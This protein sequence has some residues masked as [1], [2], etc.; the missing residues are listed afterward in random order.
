MFLKP[1][2]FKSSFLKEKELTTLPDPEKINLHERGVEY[3]YAKPGDL[4]S[5]WSGDPI[6]YPGGLF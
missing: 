1:E 6:H 3:N 4:H 2:A 5:N